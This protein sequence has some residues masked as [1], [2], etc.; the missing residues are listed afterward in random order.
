M[1]HLVRKTASFLLA[2]LSLGVASGLTACGNDTPQGGE[3]NNTCEVKAVLAGY[4][5]DWVYAMAEKFNEIYKSEGYKVEVTLTDTSIGASNEIITPKRNTTDLYFE[6]GAVNTYIDKS[7]S[8]LG[9]KGGLLLEDLSDVLNSKALGADK[10]EQ[11]K[12]I[13]ERMDETT[14]SFCEYTGRLSNVEGVY[15]LPY[16]GGTSNCLLVN[17]NVLEQNNYTTEDLLTTDDL[18]KVAY[19][20]KPSN[21]LDE[22]AFFPVAWSGS[23]AP[24]YWDYMTQMLFAQYS[25]KVAYE[26]FWNF[27]P[28][29]GST[30][31]NGYDVYE[32]NGIYEALKVVEVLEDR[33][34]AVPGTSSLDHIGAQARVFT[35]KSLFCVGGDFVYKEMEKDYAQYLD[36]VIAVKFPVISALGVKLSLCGEVHTDGDSCE[37]CDTKL[38]AIVKE[39]DTESKTDAEIAN[40]LGVAEEKVTRIKEARGYHRGNVASTACFIPSYSDSKHVAK[41]FLRFLYSDDGNDIYYAN[42]YSSLAIERVDK[43][44]TSDYS[45]R[46]LSIYKLTNTAY[47][48]PVYSYTTSPLR[49]IAGVTFMPAQGTVASMYTMLSYSHSQTTNPT[50]TAKSI[51]DTNI[52]EVQLNWV[53]WLQ[54]AGLE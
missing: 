7:R 50:L 10:K 20:L 51:Y 5:T 30:V 47:S 54:T 36:N 21:V 17:K 3:T 45:Q 49:S 46:E 29:T 8:I 40:L 15:S 4:G 25:G 38:K 18:I 28:E 1:K 26:N 14:L 42:T 33:D 9:S 52:R 16:M 11:G 22:N 2:L 53:D 13:R 27:I 31:E 48:Q 32:D 43:V 39:V 24:G 44:D 6:Y 19:A 12:T 35:G 37:S 41:L 34:L 23:K